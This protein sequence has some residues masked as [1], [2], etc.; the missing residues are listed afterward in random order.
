[1]KEIDFSCKHQVMLQ[2]EDGTL[3]PMDEPYFESEQIAPGTWR[4]RTDGDYCYLVEGDDEALMIDTGY[5]AGNIRAYAQ[6]LTEKPLYNVVNTHDHFDHTANNC[7]FDCA[8]MSEETKPLATIPF[9][10]FAGI[11]FPRD[12][13]I[14]VIDE[15]YVFHLGGRDL[16]VFK[17]PD[18]A[19]G[20][21]ALL[22]NRERLL[23]TGDEIMPM[24][25][26][27]NGSVERFLGYLKKLEA[28]RGE[29]DR[30]C[31]GFGVIEADWVEKYRENM[32]YI[33]AGHEG[34][35]PQGGPNFKPMF[36]DNGQPV[37]PRKMPHYPDIV[38]KHDINEY[39]LEMKYAGCKVTYDY[40][41]IKEEN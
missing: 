17:I 31:A 14:Q 25:K 2:N 10:S 38:G 21:I 40:R 33:M 37:Y 29:Y 1:M 39:Q 32:E 27:L 36:G 8:F 26:P 23:F 13:P 28:R 22:D 34:E 35:K 15:G 9:E 5:G 18:H 41:K 4:I 20:S 6:S 3:Q 11:D 19:V 24:G 30:L 12:Y 7:Y 16:E